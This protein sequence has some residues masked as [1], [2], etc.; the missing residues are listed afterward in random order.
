MTSNQI[1]TV[2]EPSV[3]HCLDENFLIYPRFP[4]KPGDIFSTPGGTLLVAIA[5][6]CPIFNPVIVDASADPQI[7]A[8]RIRAI[9]PETGNFDYLPIN[10]FFPSWS[11]RLYDGGNLE[12][13]LLSNEAITLWWVR[14]DKSSLTFWQGI[15][16]DG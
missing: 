10:Q 6:C 2:L 7:L 9:N 8:A 5:P 3:S 14:G 1:T 12:D 4:I 11:I 16:H 15:L 13:Y